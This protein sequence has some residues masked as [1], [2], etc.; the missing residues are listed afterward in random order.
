MKQCQI[1]PQAQETKTHLSALARSLCRVASVFTTSAGI[2][3][4]CYVQLLENLPGQGAIA[5]SPLYELSSRSAA[6]AHR[7]VHYFRLSGR[8]S[9]RAL[10]RIDFLG[11][12]S[13][14]DL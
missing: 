8:V 5:S 1:S 2:A 10:S 11:R 14:R 12:R 3:P 7:E 4:L 6:S 13:A 9:R